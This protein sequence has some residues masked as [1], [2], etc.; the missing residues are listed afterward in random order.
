[1]RERIKASIVDAAVK[2]ALHG[3][4]LLVVAVVVAVCSLDN[5]VRR[6]AISIAPPAVQEMFSETSQSRS[7]ARDYQFPPTPS[8]TPTPTPIPIATATPRAT[9]TMTPTPTHTPTPTPTPRPTPTRTVEE[10]R[11]VLI[12]LWHQSLRRS[13][14]S[15][16]DTG[17]NT[18][19]RDAVYYG[20][21]D[22]ALG[23]AKQGSLSSNKSSML[24]YVARCM[25][26]EGW[27]EWARHAA[28]H[29]PLSGPQQRIRDEIFDLEH[30][31]LRNTPPPL[32][33]QMSWVRAPE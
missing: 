25:A 7:P 21:Y 12:S 16:R 33:R 32:C 13:T 24:V 6:F 15:H 10:V 26:R 27:F 20:Q 28:D 2:Y 17:L 23:S 18:V 29:I 5:P 14:S 1:M 31:T 22:I 19:V 30:R 8:I 3:I 4:V 9:P 11:S